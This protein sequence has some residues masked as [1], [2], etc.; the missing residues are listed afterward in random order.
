MLLN[1]MHGNK[2]RIPVNS[3][4]PRVIPQEHEE[5]VPII[6]LPEQEYDV[7]RWNF[8][9]DFAVAVPSDW[10]DRMAFEHMA[11]VYRNAA[12]DE[13]RKKKWEDRTKR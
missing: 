8:G 2:I 7:K 5:E 6:G 4:P 9:V 13:R 11:Y 3:G 1:L 10:T 12:R